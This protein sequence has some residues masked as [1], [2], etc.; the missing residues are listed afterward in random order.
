MIPSLQADAEE[1]GKAA[2]GR[3]VDPQSDE[4]PFEPQEASK[5]LQEPVDEPRIASHEGAASPEAS[6]VR[7]A[8]SATWAAVDETRETGEGNEDL[9]DLN[10]GVLNFQWIRPLKRP[11]PCDAFQHGKGSCGPQITDPT[12]E[13]D[14]FSELFSE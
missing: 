4:E 9:G 12:D 3:D 14:A 8:A 11:R 5:R 2:A 13:D 10:E 7:A 1:E 6:P